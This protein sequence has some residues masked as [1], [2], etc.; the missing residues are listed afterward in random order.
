MT[1]IKADTT[2]EITLSLEKPIHLIGGGGVGMSGLGLLLLSQGYRISASDLSGGG[3]LDKLKKS[4]AETWV[5]SAPERVPPEAIIFYSSAIGS[6]DPELSVARKRGQA[7]HSRHS[8][9][10]SLTRDFYTIAVSGTHG[11]TTTSAWIA[12]LFERAGRDPS[13]LIG[14]TLPQWGSH[15]RIGQGTEQQKPLLI[16]E[17]DESDSSFLQI[18]ANEA[19]I[20]NVELDHVDH[21]AAENELYDHFRTF[22]LHCQ[23]KEGLILPSPEAQSWLPEEAPHAENLRRFYDSLQYGANTLS[24]TNVW[25]DEKRV[26]MKVSLPGRH[27]LY[28]AA[29]VV[30]CGLIHS[31]QI[32]VIAEA[33]SSFA[34]V[35]RRLETIFQAKNRHGAQ[36]TMI[37][38]YAHH[39]TEVR[40]VLDVF[41]NGETKLHAVWEPH[42]I[43]RFCHFYQE[44]T[45]TL[46]EYPGLSQVSLLPVFDAGG[47]AASGEFA[48]FTELWEGLQARV[49]ALYALD[50]AALN[51]ATEAQASQ[52]D[53]IYLFMGAGHSSRVVHEAAALLTQEIETKTESSK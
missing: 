52:K 14:G 19:L 22:I 32:S 6:S 33:L 39:P 45:E 18:E 9:L 8:L 47:E 44:F 31:L 28:N 5:G 41:R 40:A 21:Y 51:I 16:M 37:D 38:D 20:T 3:Y 10:R 2:D 4:G 49:H 15:F 13:A 27:N 29:V 12:F 26:E 50:E 7:A 35:G 46:E 42:R 23:Q 48:R 1:Q 25:G 36:I 24:F 11:K 17:A 30:A 34:G 43:S 53:V